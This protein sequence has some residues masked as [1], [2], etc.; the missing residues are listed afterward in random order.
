MKK[1][2]FCLLLAC[3]ML[4]PLTACA[5]E[6]HDLLY[7]TTVGTVTYTVRGRGERAKQIVTKE[8][9]KILWSTAVDVSDKVGNLGG[10]YG[11]E[12]VDLNFD[13][14]DDLM[15]ADDV[16][17]ECVSYLCWLKNPETGKYEESKELSG[18]CN[19]YADK[20][21]K[22]LKTFLHTYKSE[23]TAAGATSYVKTDSTT[24]YEWKDGKLIPSMRASIIYD[25]AIDQYRY[26]LYYYDEQT[27]K[28]GDESD[29]YDLWLTPEQYDQE[30][31]DSNEM[32][33]L[34]YFRKK[35]AE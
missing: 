32:G 14:H 19:I 27:G 35:S 13:G 15:I 12:V 30:Y 22:A 16:A 34:Y 21:L 20:E 3:L 18:L 7:E 8:N 10:V 1:Q 28:L 4:L 25:S 17:G 29:S 11:F 9:G 6:K 5:A 2:I 24:L 33:F 31:R 26:S 23:S